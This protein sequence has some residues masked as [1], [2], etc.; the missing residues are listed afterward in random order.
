MR[1]A[2]TVAVLLAMSCGLGSEPVSSTPAKSTSAL[3]CDAEPRQNADGTVTTL[4]CAFE[5]Q[6]QNIMAHG[7]VLKTPVAVRAGGA[8]INVTATSE[9][10]AW[11]L[12]TDEDGVM[13]FIDSTHGTVRSHGQVHPGYA[14]SKL[15][16][17]LAL[18]I[19]SN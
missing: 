16:E 13:V 17:T 8:A 4:S 11:L 7:T 5:Q 2:L 6:Y 10:G 18:P 15:P 19:V 3:A 1:A 12:G 14:T 9:C